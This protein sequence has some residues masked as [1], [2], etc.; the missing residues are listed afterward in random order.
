[1]GVE[2]MGRGDQI[3]V[4]VVMDP[5]VLV[6]RLQLR[7]LAF[8]A[9]VEKLAEWSKLPAAEI[10]AIESGELCLTTTRYEALCRGL[11]IDPVVMYRGE[12]TTERYSVER[13]RRALGV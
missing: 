7:R 4:G 1:M 3:Q 8:G 12:D 13:F 10:A 2:F 6:K 9:T 11:A 5:A